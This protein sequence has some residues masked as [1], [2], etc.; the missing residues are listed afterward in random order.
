MKTDLFYLW[1]VRFNETSCKSIGY[2]K[3]IMIAGG[4][5]GIRKSHLNKKKQNDG[6]LIII[7]GG[8]SYWICIGGGARFCF[9]PSIVDGFND[10]RCLFA[11][12]GLV[13]NDAIVLSCF[14]YFLQ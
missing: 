3:P 1:L 7:L 12:D 13:V 2:H 5:G 9:N 14:F 10:V 4:V 8:P 6:D 11:S